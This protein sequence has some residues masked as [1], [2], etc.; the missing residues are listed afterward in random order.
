[1]KKNM[2]II[3]KNGIPG[4]G[5]AP[6]AKWVSDD[7]AKLIEKYVRTRAAEEGGGK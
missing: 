4:T 1:V 3:I 6:F 5:M 7:D 2:P